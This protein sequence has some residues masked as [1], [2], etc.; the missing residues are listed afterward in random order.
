MHSIFMVKYACKNTAC[1]LSHCSWMLLTAP[2]AFLQPLPA[3]VTPHRLLQTFWAGP[4]DLR[5]LLQP[6]SLFCVPEQ[7]AAPQKQSP[8]SSALFAGGF[9]A[10]CPLSSTAAGVVLGAPQE[11]PRGLSWVRTCRS[12]LP[13]DHVSL[14]WGDPVAQPKQ[15]G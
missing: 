2:G 10:S 3:P 11:R 1:R 4:G 8:P 7:A 9:A 5:A 14:A 15:P 12:Q 13:A 6:S